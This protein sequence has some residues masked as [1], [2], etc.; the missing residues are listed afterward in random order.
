MLK[1]LEN[2][3]FVSASKLALYVSDLHK[4]FITGEHNLQSKLNGLVSEIKN[5]KLT[6]NREIIQ[7]LLS[8]KKKVEHF[9]PLIEGRNGLIEFYDEVGKDNNDLKVF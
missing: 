6:D 7:K 4:T 9:R 8:Y 3:E 1:V 2:K 5:E